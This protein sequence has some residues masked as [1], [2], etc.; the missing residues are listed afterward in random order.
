MKLSKHEA[1]CVKSAQGEEETL[2]FGFTSDCQEIVTSLIML[3]AKSLSRLKTAQDKRKKIYIYCSPC[4]L[5]KFTHCPPPPH[6]LVSLCSNVSVV[7]ECICLPWLL[8]L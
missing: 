2:D 8:D 4:T 5:S 3:N 7:L 6:L 1:I